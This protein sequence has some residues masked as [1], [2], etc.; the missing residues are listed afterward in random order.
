MY[1]VF[2]AKLTTKCRLSWLADSALVYE[3]KC[4]EGVGGF[5]GSQPIMSTAVHTE[6]K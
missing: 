4:W 6:P 3:P 1:I 5:A 2:T